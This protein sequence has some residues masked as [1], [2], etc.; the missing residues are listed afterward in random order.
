MLVL[1]LWYKKCVFTQNIL[2]CQTDVF[3]RALK[4]D[5]VFGLKMTYFSIYSDVLPK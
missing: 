3:L 2:H 5:G 4:M 1:L